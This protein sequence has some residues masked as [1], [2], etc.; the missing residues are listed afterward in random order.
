[1]ESITISGGKRL[2]GTLELSGSKNAV[3]PILAAT[4]AIGEPCEISNCP[5]IRDV[6]TALEILDYLGCRVQKSGHTVTVDASRR[7]GA[8]VPE[9]LSLQM[10]SSVLFLGALAGAGQKTELH[11]PG[12]CVLGKRPIDLHLSGLQTLGAQI[13]VE[14]SRI[15]CRE[16]RLTG[17]TVLL[18]YPSVGATENLMLAALGAAAP[19][20]IVGAAREPEIADLADFLTACGASV[21]GAGTSAIRISGGKLHGARYGVMPDRMEAVTYLSAAASAGG[22]L[23]VTGAV[24]GHITPVLQ[25]LRSAGCKIT[26]GED[27]IRLECDRLCA[28]RPVLT[29][30]YP[31]FPTDA[32]PTVMAAMLK[33]EGVTVFAETVFENRFRQ[34]PELRKLGADITVAGRIA[35]VRGVKTLHSAQM[36][37]TDLRGGAAMLVAALGAEGMSTVTHLQY[38]ERGYEKL[39]EKLRAIGAEITEETSDKGSE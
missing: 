35:A 7:T 6:D 37:A 4:A 21:I 2:C 25:F 20:M 18:P 27:R 16:G 30:P 14:G 22:D 24:P 3:L 1:M 10:R 28:G 29:G 31:A 17:G 11:T 9:D 19:V 15:L 36:N 23:T 33:A 13:T 5:S 26:C 8:A 12:G 39:T 34:V 38:V 32:Q